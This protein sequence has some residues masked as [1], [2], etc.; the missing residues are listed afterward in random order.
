MNSDSGNKLNPGDRVRV[1]HRPELDGAYSKAGRASRVALNGQICEAIEVDAPTAHV[2]G[3]DVDAWFELSEIEL[4]APLDVLDADVQQALAAARREAQGWHSAALLARGEA[5]AAR[6]RLAEVEAERDAL[7]GA[8][9]AVVGPAVGVS[10]GALS[11]SVRAAWSI[12]KAEQAARYDALACERAAHEET[13]RIADRRRKERDAAVSRALAAEAALAAERS[14]H[15][16]AALGADKLARQIAAVRAAW[17]R[18]RAFLLALPR[19]LGAAGIEGVDAVDKALGGVAVAKVAGPW[20][21]TPAGAWYRPD[22]S[23]KDRDAARVGPPFA[24][25]GPANWYTDARSGPE[26]GDA[27]KA[28]ADRALLAAGWTLENETG[29]TGDALPCELTVNFSEWHGTAHAVSTSDREPRRWRLAFPMTTPLAAAEQRNLVAPGRIKHDAGIGGW[30]GR[31][32]VVQRAAVAGAAIE[33]EVV[34]WIEPKEAKPERECC[35]EATLEQ[36]VAEV[37]A[38]L[39]RLESGEALAKMLEDAAK[40]AVG[41]RIFGAVTP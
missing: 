41:D 15:E 31:V 2:R 16:T 26:K 35:W 12:L 33:L 9:E 28:A 4:A 37:E 10:A 1:R 3:A 25:P 17:G 32:M 39:G 14:I 34:E 13:G 24:D 22:R 27:G 5:D 7:R 6:E 36:R 18:M 40:R 20:V 23:A 11:A 29:G 38:R 21:L 19:P 8:C 30:R